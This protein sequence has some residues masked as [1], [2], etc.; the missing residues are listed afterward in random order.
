[1]TPHPPAPAPGRGSVRARCARLLRGTLT[2]PLRDCSLRE[3][4]V[5]PWG[6]PAAGLLGKLFALV[7]ASVVALVVAGCG[8]STQRPELERAEGAVPPGQTS[9]SPAKKAPPWVLKRGGGYYQDDGPGDDVPDNLD[10]IA[11]AVPRLEPLHRFANNPYSVLGKEYT[12]KKMLGGYRARGVA[13]WYGRKFHGQKTSSGEPYDMY[14]MTAAHPTLP[15]PSYVRV[16]NPANRR[17]VILRVNDRG[18]FLSGRLIDLSYTAAWKLGYIGEG[19]TLVEVESILP[20]QE[21]LLAK[22][23]TAIPEPEEDPI[24]RIAELGAPAPTPL[25]DVRVGGSHFLQLGAFG[26]RDN[27]EALQA[28]LGRQLGDLAGKLVIHSA[29]ALHRVQ[30][31]PWPDLPAAKRAAEK[32]RETLDFLPVVVAR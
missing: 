16:T 9:G 17:S 27:A 23:P 8:T 21:T 7:L 30:L 3:R 18:P 19:S 20:G 29:G 26:N 31:G 28:R 14:A 1:M 2:G 5:L 10:A 4:S 15:I 32:L 12:P 24:A 22:A 13:S 25:P 11:D 6:G